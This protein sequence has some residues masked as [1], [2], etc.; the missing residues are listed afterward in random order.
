MAQRNFLNKY[1]RWRWK[2]RRHRWGLRYVAGPQKGMLVCSG[3]SMRGDG[4][5]VHLFATKRDAKAYR[6]TWHDDGDAIVVKVTVQYT[7][8]L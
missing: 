3:Y 4:G 2:E 7:Q 8:T 1:G 6:K 5:Q